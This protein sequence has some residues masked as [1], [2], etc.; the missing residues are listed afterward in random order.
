MNPDVLPQRQDNRARRSF[1]LPHSH[2]DPH[3]AIP[4]PH[5]PDYQW[6]SGCGVPT[7]ASHDDQCQHQPQPQHAEAR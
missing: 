7:P 5:D 1:L 2:D 3:G 4:I 6:C